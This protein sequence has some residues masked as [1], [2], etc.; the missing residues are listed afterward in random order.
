MNHHPYLV[1]YTF[2]STQSFKLLGDSGRVCQ[3]L[4]NLLN[5]AIKFTPA[6]GTVDLSYKIMSETEN[7]V[8][9]K[10]KI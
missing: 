1:V 10:V 6:G 9:I 8:T 2:I 7:N 3:I 5:N 4:M